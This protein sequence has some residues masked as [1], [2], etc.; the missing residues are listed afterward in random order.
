MLDDLKLVDTIVLIRK[1][2]YVHFC[3]ISIFH[4]TLGRKT[5]PR[6]IQAL[7]VTRR[8]AVPRDIENQQRS[9]RYLLLNRTMVEIGQQLIALDIRFE[10]CGESQDCVAL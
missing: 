3:A 8:T 6:T 4:G 7:L 10:F 1:Q 5:I 2:Q 9:I